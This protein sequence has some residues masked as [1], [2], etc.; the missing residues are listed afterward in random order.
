MNSFVLSMA[1]AI[2]LPMGL[3]VGFTLVDLVDRWRK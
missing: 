3:I 1:V 2:A